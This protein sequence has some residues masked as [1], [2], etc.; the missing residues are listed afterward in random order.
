MLDVIYLLQLRPTSIHLYIFYVKDE[1]LILLN[2][3]GQV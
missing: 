3:R 2:T 1:S